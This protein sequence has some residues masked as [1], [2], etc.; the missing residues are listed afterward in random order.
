M[1]PEF[2]PPHEG[3]NE[4]S[5]FRRGYRAPSAPLQHISRR[6]GNPVLAQRLT[7][8]LFLAPPK[9][10][11]KADFFISASSRSPI[12]PRVSPSVAR[13]MK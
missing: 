5:D 1:A 7:D 3:S 6:A 9:P 2:A 12:I 4:V 11:M 8:R 13:S 10:Q